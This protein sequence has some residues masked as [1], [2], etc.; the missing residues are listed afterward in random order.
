MAKEKT[1]VQIDN[2]VVND[3]IKMKNIGD[4]YS[5]VIRKL[6]KEQKKV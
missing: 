5:D 6:I 1:K 2:D 4:T 3:L